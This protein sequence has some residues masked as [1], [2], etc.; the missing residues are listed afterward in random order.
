MEGTYIAKLL[1]ECSKLTGLLEMISYQQCGS[2]QYCTIKVCQIYIG[3]KLDYGAPAYSSAAKSTLN[4]LDAITTESMRIATGAFRTTPIETLYVL[5]NELKPQDRRDYLALRY[6]YKIKENISNPA[7]P[8]LIPVTYR[9]L[10]RNKILPL[11]LSLR[12][13]DMLEKYKLRKQF[14]KPQFSYYILHINTPT[15]AVSPPIVN[16][17]RNEYSKI[18]T[19]P[20][21]YKHHYNMLIQIRYNNYTKLFTDGSKRKEKVG[22]AVVWDD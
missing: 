5:A 3:S 10:F 13:Q 2:D 17:R 11:L 21:R 1:S 7:Y 4:Q 14:I 12:I 6:F 8:Y 22:A 16:L 20:A 15:W 19:P 9:T 18:I